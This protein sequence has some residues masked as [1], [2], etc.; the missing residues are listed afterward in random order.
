IEVDASSSF[1]RPRH[2]LPK[3]LAP[4]LRTL[5]EKA[6]LFPHVHGRCLGGLGE[7][8][9]TEALHT[10]CDV[11]T[12]ALSLSGYRRDGNR[13]AARVDNEFQYRWSKNQS[14]GRQKSNHKLTVEHRLVLLDP[15]AN[16]AMR[17]DH[18]IIPIIMQARV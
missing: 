5:V 16:A 13:R 2:C 8:V 3:C 7:L 4:T 11:S 12:A 6:Q 17:N 1:N 18:L 14:C 10:E 15:V 9:E